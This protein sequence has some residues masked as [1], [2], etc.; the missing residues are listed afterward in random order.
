M[1]ISKKL[2]TSLVFLLCLTI[3]LSFTY[4]VE[5]EEKIRVII[6]PSKNSNIKVSALLTALSS[7]S[8][9]K[10]VKKLYYLKGI[11]AYVTPAKME[12]LRAKGYRVYRDIKVHALLQQSIPLIRADKVWKILFN[13]TN[14]TGKGV[15]VC[16]LDTGINYTIPDLGGCFGN[17]TNFTC[18]V[19][20][21]YDYINN[22]TDPMDD[23]GH[24]TH[25]AGIIAANGSLK[26]VAP[27]AKLI[28]M[29]VLDA[30]GNGYISYA[31]D[32]ILWCVNHS[33][34]YNITVI[35]MSL[36]AGVYTDFCDNAQTYLTDAINQAVA[37]GIVVV[38]ATGNDANYSGVSLPACIYNAT[39]VGATYDSDYIGNSFSYLNGLGNVICTDTSPYR[40][41]ITCF[42]NRGG[43]FDDML[44]APGA[45]INST[46]LNGSYIEKAGTSMAAPFVSGTIALMKQVAPT[47]SPAKIKDV[48]NKTGKRIYDP[49][50]NRSYTRID[51]YAAI[52][53]LLNTSIE[54]VKVSPIYGNTSTLFN[55]TAVWFSPANT[56]P[57]EINLSID[58][59]NYSMIKANPSDNDATDGIEY[60]VNITLPYGIH[61]FKI[62]AVDN[63]T[64]KI[65]ETNLFIGPYVADVFWI[66]ETV[67]LKDVSESFDNLYIFSNSSV[68]LIKNAS[69]D[70]NYTHFLYKTLPTISVD[71][72]SSLTIRNTM[73]N[74]TILSN[75][76]LKI[77]DT[78][79]NVSL[80]LE[81]GNITILNLTETNNE[82]SILILLLTGNGNISSFDYK[83]GRIYSGKIYGDFL[84][85]SI[86]N[87]TISN[88]AV[89]SVNASVFS[90]DSTIPNIVLINTSLNA[91]NTTIFWLLAEFTNSS[92]QGYVE[93][94]RIDI[95]DNGSLTRYFPIKFVR[96]IY[97]NETNANISIYNTSQ[98]VANFS[99]N[100]FSWIP[101]VFTPAKENYTIYVKNYGYAQVNGSK[102]VL[103]ANMN[104]IKNITIDVVYPSAMLIASNAYISPLT[105]RGVKDNTTLQILALSE[106]VMKEKILIRRVPD[107]QIIR[108]LSG[109][110]FVW[111]GTD[112]T[113]NELSDGTF[114]ICFNITDYYGNS[115]YTCVLNITIDNTL[116]KIS[117]QTPPLLLNSTEMN[118]PLNISEQ[119]LNLTNLTVKSTCENFSKVFTTQGLYSISFIPNCTGDY[120]FEIYAIDKAGNHILKEFNISSV[121]PKVIN[122]SVLL[123]TSGHLA[124]LYHGYP[125][126]EGNVTKSD[127]S[128]I[129]IPYGERVNI[130]LSTANAF[131]NLFNASFNDS[132]KIETQALLSLTGQKSFAKVYAINVL[133][134]SFSRAYL[135][136]NYTD[137]LPYIKNENYLGLYVCDLW[138]FTERKCKSTWTKLTEN[139]TFNTELHTVELN[140]THFSAF[141]IFQEPYCGD[142]IV[143][144]PTEECDGS[145]FNGKTC[146][147]FGYD[148]GVLKCTATCKIDTSGCYYEYDQPSPGG[149]ATQ[150]ENET[151]NE[152]SAN[153]NTTNV[154]TNITSNITNTTNETITKFDF[155]LKCFAN[156]TFFT[157]LISIHISLSSLSNETATVFLRAFENS[158]LLYKE[159]IEL[160]PLEEKNIS[161]QL[162]LSKGNHT[163]LLYANNKTCMLFF[164]IKLPEIYYTIL[165][166]TEKIEK[167]LKALNQSLEPVKK[168]RIYLNNG[169]YEKAKELLETTKSLLSKIKGEKESTN[170][171]I[172]TPAEGE[173]K[174]GINFFTVVMLA[175]VIILAACTLVLFFVFYP[176]FRKKQLLKEIEALE[177]FFEEKNIHD[178]EIIEEISN[179]KKEIEMNML[180]LASLRIK[181]IKKL[182]EILK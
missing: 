147:D 96:D 114:E 102:V 158:T 95:K 85:F 67:L 61:S 65:V 93:I 38:V 162:T 128:I 8:G 29:K 21:G 167:E 155:E 22:D 132:V 2:L 113:G 150:P 11:V 5:T 33:S 112:N 173:K 163:I 20:D 115:N 160:L 84:N 40:D 166:E 144:Q 52:A 111:N 121:L 18:K 64:G 140:T 124:V 153:I 89:V 139:V 125:Y 148:K 26:G 13:R 58:G 130:S 77:F 116:P 50:T 71:E 176:K 44:L 63:T 59:K 101:L 82:T 57:L 32:A 99:I 1:G 134:T 39:R 17:G 90:Y 55:F 169:E 49:Q 107:L 79:G 136:I 54:D 178:E 174:E 172:A 75:G 154:T 16:V 104:T 30:S 83:D 94:G 151:T 51:A 87:S 146:L 27:D 72:N 9:I 145:D 141:A 25:V 180:N 74:G 159:D 31:A 10:V 73:F 78:I 137:A 120:T 12:E 123:N 46:W 66:N 161:I 42:T 131:I 165:S 41:N 118:I 23:N 138:N 152:T 62:V 47:L 105:S 100:G 86:F 117:T 171:T 157:K 98:V 69:V 106:P 70:F 119:N 109:N 126:F 168:I 127:S 4:A 170:K 56:F 34:Q 37:K 88:I 91:S 28:A 48:L 53:Y 181:K 149:T 110:S 108:D 164:K 43:V 14:I 92:L 36:G 177:K 15:S 179:A 175:L 133:N 129:R 142:G 19:I 35:S 135:R 45:W 60:F 156:K 68:A 24:G 76:T 3:F 182:A 122:L 97:G 81:K 6:L 143:N 7:E 103:R 80:Y